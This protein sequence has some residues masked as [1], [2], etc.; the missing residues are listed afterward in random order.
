[1]IF[2]DIIQLN[3]TTLFLLKIVLLFQLLLLHYQFE[4]DDTEIG[5]NLPDK[6]DDDGEDWKF[7][8]LVQVKKMKIFILRPKQANKA[9]IPSADWKAE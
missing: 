2:V 8:E 9:G 5:S 6:M 3:K 4:V 1:V 7:K